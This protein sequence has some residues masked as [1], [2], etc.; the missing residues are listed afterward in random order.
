MIYAWSLLL[1]YTGASVTIIEVADYIYCLCSSGLPGEVNNDIAMNVTF[2]NGNLSCSAQCNSKL[3]QRQL[4]CV[5]NEF[6]WIEYT[7]TCIGIMDKPTV[8]DT[9]QFCCATDSVNVS[10][11][12]VSTCKDLSLYEKGGTNVA[13]IIG[14]AAVALV[15][16]SATVIVVIAVVWKRNVAR[17]RHYNP[18]MHCTHIMLHNIG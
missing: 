18:G 15:I 16:A 8:P 9:E 10:T 6:T 17:R 7:G 1:L 2:I 3:Y 14:F 13:T 11:T 12:T 4:P 5:W